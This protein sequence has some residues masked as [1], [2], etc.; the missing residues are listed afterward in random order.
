M[1]GQMPPGLR[2]WHFPPAVFDL[3]VFGQRV[4]YP[5]KQAG[6]FTQYAR[7]FAGCRLTRVSV[8]FGQFVGRSFE[9]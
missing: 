3:F 4:M 5:G 8:L 2:C 7:D 6:V 9:R 1:V